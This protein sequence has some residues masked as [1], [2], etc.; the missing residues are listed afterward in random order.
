MQFILWEN[1]N[2]TSYAQDFIESHGTVLALKLGIRIGDLQNASFAN[3]LQSQTIKKIRGEL[4]EIRIKIKKINYR[5]LFVRREN[6]GWIV[7]AFVKKT[8]KTPLKYIETAER[9]AKM[10]V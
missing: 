10:I 8:N 5:F 3:L 7:E 6:V 1:E 4:Y 2:G 9:R